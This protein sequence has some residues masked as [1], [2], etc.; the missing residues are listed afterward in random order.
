M[1]RGRA[2]CLGRHGI[3]GGMLPR[4]GAHLQARSFPAGNNFL[5]LGLGHRSCG[6]SSRPWLCSQP[7]SDTAGSRPPR[8]PK[9]GERLG[10]RTQL[11][12]RMP[13][14][15][16]R[17]P[18]RFTGAHKRFPNRGQPGPQVLKDTCEHRVPRLGFPPP[19]QTCS[20]SQP[21]G[22]GWFW[23]CMIAR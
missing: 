18:D 5:L 14:R 20:G 15:P 13:R 12:V 19:V 6:G 23:S 8:A 22:P 10:S 16:Q 21:L 4:A 1:Q 2:R 9:R 11:L 7:Y 3:R 17:L